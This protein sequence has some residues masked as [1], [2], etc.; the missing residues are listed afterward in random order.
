M[1]GL[2]D[3]LLDLVPRL[4]P[5]PRVTAEEY[6]VIQCNRCGGCCEDIRSSHGPDELATLLAGG[7]FDADRQSFSEGLVPIEPLVDGW[8]YRCKH[9]KRDTEGLGVCAIYDRRPQVCRSYPNGGS[10]RRWSQCAFYVQIVGPDGT[11]IPM[12]PPQDE[13][14]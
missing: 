7:A 6:R 3:L 1:A 5:A 13:P 14:A 8:R 11:V 2:A 12:V 4:K 10:V 9:F